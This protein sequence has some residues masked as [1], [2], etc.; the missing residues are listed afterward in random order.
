MD[1][2]IISYFIMAY[3]LSILIIV[4]SSMTI[5]VTNNFD[6]LSNG[7]KTS[8]KW[9]AGVSLAASFSVLVAAPIVSFPQDNRVVLAIYLFAIFL[10]ALIGA[11]SGISIDCVNNSNKSSSYKN[12]IR[13]L[14]GTSITMALIAI[15]GGPLLVLADQKT[16]AMVLVAMLLASLI[17]ATSGM[18]IH[19]ASSSPS[20]D[21]QKVSRGVSGVALAGAL[22]GFVGIP[23]MAYQMQ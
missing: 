4:I 7:Y 14:G 15:I 5:N 12:A 18:G 20:D 22:V 16:L 13:G 1:P 11:L 2:K 10:S 21:Y 9:V 6:T 19:A 23:L 8:V 17:A 3:V